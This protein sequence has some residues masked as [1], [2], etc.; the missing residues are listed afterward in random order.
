MIGSFR[1]SLSAWL[2]TTLTADLY[3][4]ADPAMPLAADADTFA[5]LLRVP[6]IAGVS[7]ART[8][9]LPTPVGE[10]AVRAFHPGARGFGLTMVGGEPDAALAALADGRGV[11]ASERL[12]FARGLSVGDELSLPGPSGPQ[13]LPI[14]GT[15]RD[16]NTGNYTIVMALERYRTGW[17][18]MTITGLGVD[19]QDGA[20]A[21]EVEAAVRAVF[22]QRADL[23]IRSSRGIEQLSLVVFDRTFRITEVLRL[24]AAVVAFL[25]VLSALLAIELERSHELGVLR[26]L[27]FAPRDLAISL[28]TQTGLLGLAAGLVAVPLGTGLAALLVHVINRRSFGW[29]MDFTPTLE[30][31]A[32]GLVLAVGAALLAGVYPSWR[33]S[34]VVLGTALREE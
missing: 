12:M 13:R 27:G 29:T 3:V 18:D 23:R 5:A 31:L 26:A 19:L 7:L 10:I 2:D 15:Y 34:R 6:G 22:G 21:A 20:N 24:L 14:V 8:L 30:P 17:N 9:T 28:L 16:F 1:T 32:A 25:G 11:V 33:A 4:T